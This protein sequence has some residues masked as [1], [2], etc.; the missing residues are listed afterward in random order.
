M[1]EINWKNDFNKHRRQMPLPPMVSLSEARI[2][3]EKELFK[4]ILS[5]ERTPR[6]A[7]NTMNHYK[8]LIAATRCEPEATGEWWLT[9]VVEIERA[10]Q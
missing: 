2:V 6:W 5:L 8:E 3:I 10:K 9:H 1:P 7:Q 4:Q